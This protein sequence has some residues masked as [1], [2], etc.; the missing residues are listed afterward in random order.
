MDGLLKKLDEILDKYGITDNR[1][2]IKDEIYYDV[3]Q[4]A[5]HAGFDDGKDPK[6]F[7]N[8]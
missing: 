4:E 7:W 5:Y 8:D 3:I 6:T 1:D 2:K